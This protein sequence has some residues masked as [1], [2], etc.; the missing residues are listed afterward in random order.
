[1]RNLI[2]TH[3]QKNVN[4]FLSKK[5]AINQFVNIIS[6][7]YSAGRFEQSFN[8]GCEDSAGCV[9]IKLSQTVL[10]DFLMGVFY[11]IVSESA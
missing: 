6:G 5:P 1:V 7:S 8:C 4:H 10:S 2:V 3:G 9:K 11:V